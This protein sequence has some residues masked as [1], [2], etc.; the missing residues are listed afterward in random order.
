MSENRGQCG[1]GWEEVKRSVLGFR[2]PV[3]EGEGNNDFWGKKIKLRGEG[4]GGSGSLLSRA[5]T[6]QRGL[7]L[8]P[9]PASAAFLLREHMETLGWE[10][11]C[12]CCYFINKSLYPSLPGAGKDWEPSTGGQLI[13]AGGRWCSEPGYAVTESSIPPSYLLCEIQSCWNHRLQWGGMLFCL[14]Q[15]INY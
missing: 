10:M 7:T 2:C 1:V 14:M 12:N 13:S 11:L 6:C 8:H 9:V 5:F 15:S 3:V 4:H